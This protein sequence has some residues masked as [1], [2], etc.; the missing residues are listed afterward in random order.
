MVIILKKIARNF[1]RF[2]F[3]KNAL[4]FLFFLLLAAAFW[5]SHT[6]NKLRETNITIPLRYSTLPPNYAITN[7][8]PQEIKLSIRDEGLN[9]FSYS[10][11]RLVA[12]NIDLLKADMSK[13]HFKLTQE[14]VFSRLSNY[15]QPTTTI[16]SFS[17]DTIYVS[18]EKLDSVVLPVK[19]DANIELAQQ[20][21]LSNEIQL[22]PSEI[23]VFG[24][25]EILKNLNEIRTEHLELKQLNDTVSLK[26]P[27][28]PVELVNFSVNEVK[29]SI[30]SEM[31]TE[32]RLQLPVTFVNVPDNFSVRS[33]PA[34]VDVAYNI[35]L[36]HYNTNYDNVT[37]VVDYEDIIQN[38][39][40]KQRLKVIN[41][42]SKTF[43]IRLTPEEIEFVLEER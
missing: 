41:N 22:I 28:L 4:S 39:Q 40:E 2:L 11:K 18:Y 21:I 5:F 34:V 29:V 37:V 24:N 7:Q 9:L 17:P 42:S 30:K 36:S 13:E 25:P 6:A 31:F 1:K 27:L 15:L 38:K 20:Y 12:L 10:K 43:N 3:S 14:Q 33:F 8:P 16:L 23:T 32:K 35:G 26:I 19:L